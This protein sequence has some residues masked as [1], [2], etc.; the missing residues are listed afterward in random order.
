M[1]PMKLILQNFGPYVNETVDFER[2]QQNGLFLITGKTGSG[3]TTIFEALTF[4]LYGSTT[5]DDRPPESLRSDFA[6]S[7]AAT[8]VQLTFEHRGKIYQVIRLPKQ[9]LAKKRGVGDKEYESRGRLKIFKD[10]QQVDELTK[11]KDINL[12]LLDVLQLSRQQFI[13][14]VLLPQGAFRRFLMASS[15]DKE[16]VLRKIFRTQLYQKWTQILNDQLKDQQ[17]Q[18]KQLHQT[19]TTDLTKIHW[20][21]TPVSKALSAVQQ[22]A[23]LEQQQQQQHAKLTHRQA[24]QR[25]RQAQLQQR[26]QALSEHQKINNQIEQLAQLHQTQQSLQQQQDNFEQV[27]HQIQQLT[28]VKDRQAAV[29]QIQT[30]Q[31]Q[32]QAVTTQQTTFVHRQAQLQ[33]QLASAKATQQDLIQK[34]PQDRHRQAQLATLNAQRKSYVQYQQL[35]DQLTEAHQQVEQA[36][37]NLQQTKAQVEQV[38]T[39]YQQALNAVQT[40]PDLLQQQQW[41]QNLVQQL[42]EWQHH[43]QIEQELEHQQQHLQDQFVYQQQVVAQ[44]QNHQ[45]ALKDQWL[46]NQI[47][48]LAAQLSPDQPCPVCGSLDHPVPNTNAPK[49][50]T[51]SAVKLADKQLTTSQEALVRLQTQIQAQQSQLEVQQQAIV[52]IQVTCQ[53]LCQQLAISIDADDLAEPVAP[54]LAQ[55]QDHL[56]QL[57]VRVQKVQHQ[58]QTVA[59]TK[60]RLQN[61]NETLTQWQTKHQSA[62]RVYQ[63]LSGQQTMLAQQLPGKYS[64]LAAVD[65]AITQLAQQVQDF[66]EQLTKNQQQLQRDHQQQAA[67]NAQAELVQQQLAQISQTLQANT[68]QLTAQVQAYFGENSQQRFDQLTAQLPQLTHLQQAVSDYEQRCQTVATQIQVYQQLIGSQRQFDVTAEH[69]QLVELQLQWDADAAATEQFYHQVLNNDALLQQLRQTQQELTDRQDQEDQLQI[70]AE[71][72]AGKSAAKLSLERF[73]LRAQLVD[74]LEVANQHLQQF[75]SGRYYMLLH[76]AQGTYQKDTG[77]EIDVYDDNVGEV[78]SVHTLSGGESFLAALSLALALGEVIQEQAGG[79]Q[80]EALFI[81]EGFGSLDQESLLIA[82]RALEQ[83][84]TGHQVIGIISHVALLKEQIPNQLVVHANDQGQSTVQLKISD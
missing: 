8:S 72:M 74:I 24:Q 25:D 37:Q 26:Q 49:A 61:L 10:A 84:Q 9:I 77:L 43:Q 23:D 68:Q 6:S 70:L 28:W 46:Q 36:Y 56:Q 42:H 31:Q 38:Q 47:A 44:C 65:Q 76:Q 40:L 59:Q 45:R 48:T 19:L 67:L 60:R 63:Q 17:R 22:I 20:V 11:L 69:Q 3:K 80:I 82:L 18:S 15:V 34:T 33:Q 16:Q 78:R 12:K 32:Q 4:A 81:D 55:Q 21:T 58:Q 50:V 1:R 39:T 73:V 53:E 57:T 29:Q 41:T 5:S 83:I 35:Q 54:I 30:L 13:Q 66:S 2:L 27:K 51:A 75:S 71:T 52:Q 14:I 7:Q 64:D 79:V 62:Q